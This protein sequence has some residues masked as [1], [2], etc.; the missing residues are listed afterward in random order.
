MIF[1]FLNG[2]MKSV[3]FIHYFNGNVQIVYYLFQGYKLRSC[4]LVSGVIIAK[5]H[6]YPKDFSN[7]KR[8]FNLK[9][10]YHHLSNYYL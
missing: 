8:D 7:F 6:S 3:N 5:R 9:S 4:F 10:S 1:F 2:V